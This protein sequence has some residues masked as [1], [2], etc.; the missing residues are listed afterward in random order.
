MQANMN[1]SIFKT[2]AII[3]SGILSTYHYILKTHLTLSQVRIDD[4]AGNLNAHFS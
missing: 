2:M 4:L 3:Q 1:F